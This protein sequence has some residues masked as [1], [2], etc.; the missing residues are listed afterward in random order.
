MQLAQMDEQRRLLENNLKRCQFL[1]SHLVIRWTLR[2]DDDND[3]K[4]INDDD[5]HDTDDTDDHDNDLWSLTRFLDLKK[6]L[7]SFQREAEESD[8]VV[9]DFIKV[10]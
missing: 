4:V 6:E 8:R 2:D 3:Q 1:F 10:N 7:S 5:H 9:N